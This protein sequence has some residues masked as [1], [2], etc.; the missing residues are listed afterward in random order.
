[1]QFEHVVL[2]GG[3]TVIAAVV[4]AAAELD[5]PKYTDE[6]LTRIEAR[7]FEP[8]VAARQVSDDYLAEHKF[9]QIQESERKEITN[10]VIPQHPQG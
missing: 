8:R 10:Y 7:Y 2:L 1:M 4:I 6:E 9:K 3:I 5:Q